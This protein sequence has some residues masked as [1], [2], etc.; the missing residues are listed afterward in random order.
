MLLKVKHPRTIFRLAMGCLLVFS[1]LG[2]MNPASTFS[3]DVV[4]GMRGAL[5]GATIVLVYLTFRLKRTRERD[6]S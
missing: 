4:D 5:L 6:L 2:L 3:Q 1:G